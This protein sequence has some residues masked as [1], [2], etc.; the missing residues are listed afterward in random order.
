MSLTPSRAAEKAFQGKN[1]KYLRIANVNGLSFKPIIF[2]TN[3]RMHED[4][5]KFVRKYTKHASEVKG[6]EHSIVD[7]Y[8]FNRLSCV[9]QKHI[10]NAILTRSHSVNSHLPGSAANHIMRDDFVLQH[11]VF[12]AGGGARRE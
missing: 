2:E 10:A 5:V 9:I 8:A 12:Y 11:D 1:R 6:I 4:S 7:G 3:G